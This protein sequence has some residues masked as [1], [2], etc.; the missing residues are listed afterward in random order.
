MPFQD[1]PKAVPIKRIIR[2]TPVVK[3]YVL[4]LS[5]GA[6][7]GQFVNVWLPGVD[8]KPLSVAFDDGKEMKITVAAIGKMTKAL[9]EKKAGDLIGIRGPYGNGFS[10]KPKQRI[11]M[12]AGGYGAAPLYFCAY[13]AAKDG[14]KIDF[15]MG[16]RT[17][18]YL[19]YEKQFKKIKGLTLHIATD[20]GSAGFKGFNVALFE[21]ALKQ[22]KKYDMVMTCGPE[23]MAK[24]VS[25]ICW[26]KKIRAQIDMERYMKCGFGICGNCC[27][28]DGGFPL[29]KKGTVLPNEL[30][31]KIKDFGSYYRDDLGKK[32][33]F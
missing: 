2:E 7:P 33:Y 15:F 3:T 20:D 8:E 5:L 12:I 24:K 4:P 23:I 25:D 1:F 19:L 29:C 32:H 27:V 10:W 6:R 18:S 30:V 31:R 22:G 13:K 26:K 14:C 28:D 11:A 16:A 9:D 17:K 21:N